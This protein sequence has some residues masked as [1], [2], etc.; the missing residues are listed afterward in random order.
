[1][2]YVNNTYQYG[3][4]KV[5]TIVDL[6][7]PKEFFICASDLEKVSP[8]YTVHSY[9]ER[10]DTKAL[11]EA[12]PK[13]GC[14]NQPIDGGR[15]IKTVAEGANRG[16]WF[17]RVL[18]LD[19]C[20][21]TSPKLFVWC[22]SVCNRIAS[23]SATT[24]KKSLYSTTEVIKFLEGDWNVKTL[25]SDLE[26]KGVI[27]F[28]QSSSSKDRKWTMCDKS[29][30]RFIKEKTFTIKDTNFTKP[31]NVWTEEGKNYLINL[32]NK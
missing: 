11:M 23:T 31:Y 18:A 21:W 7:D 22:E 20:R 6:D 27:K 30:L 17:C 4:T 24:D 19:F 14:K 25:L 13:S 1:M 29:K 16:T 10:D 8:I 5:R 12:I 28:S 9:L 32:Y 2:N 15:L 3:P 26:K